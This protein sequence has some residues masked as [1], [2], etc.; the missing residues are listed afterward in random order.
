MR[1]ESGEM[2]AHNPRFSDLVNLIR[3][4]PMAIEQGMPYEYAFHSGQL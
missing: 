2:K 3:L 4:D 1:R